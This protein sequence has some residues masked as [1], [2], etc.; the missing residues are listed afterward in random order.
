MPECDF[1]GFF[2][3]G[4]YTYLAEFNVPKNDLERFKGTKFVVGQV[5]KHSKEYLLSGFEL[6]PL[7]PMRNL[8]M[9]PVKQVPFM[10]K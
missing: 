10:A 1:M 3:S 6:Q 5:S 7:L 4:Q 8:R 2:F 9:T